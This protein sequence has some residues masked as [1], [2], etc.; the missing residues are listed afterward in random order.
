MSGATSSRG[1]TALTIN[2]TIDYALFLSAIIFLL[3]LMM[4]AICSV[5]LAQ[6][7]SSVHL[8]K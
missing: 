3:A 7:E 8:L 6:A 2:T 5:Y 1:H 4:L